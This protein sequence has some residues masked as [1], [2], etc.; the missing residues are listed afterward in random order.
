MQHLT[1]TEQKVAELVGTQGLTN[2]QVAEVTG[3]SKR[4][5]DAHL[6]NIYRKLELRN[7]AELIIYINKEGI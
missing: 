1:P 4:T 3:N 5:I 2:A 6:A 7:R